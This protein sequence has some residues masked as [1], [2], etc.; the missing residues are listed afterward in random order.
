LIYFINPN[1]VAVSKPSHRC[2]VVR[3]VSLPLVDLSHH[4]T[5]APFAWVALCPVVIRAAHALDTTRAN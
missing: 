3:S 5:P 4:K 1:L 2:R